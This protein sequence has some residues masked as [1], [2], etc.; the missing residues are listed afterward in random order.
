MGRLRQSVPKSVLGILLA[1]CAGCGQGATSESAQRQTS[2]PPP[3]QDFSLTLS[4]SSV[5]VLQGATTSALNISV[6]GQ[7]G[8]AGG[9]QVTL[10]GLPRGVLSNPASP[11]SMA[12]NTSVPVVLGAAASA[13][14][15]NFNV[16]VVGTSN[17]LSHSASL[18]LV[19]Q[20]GILSGLPRTTYV[21]TDSI[22]TLDDPR[23]NLATAG[24]FTM[25]RINTFLWP[26]APETAWKFSP[27]WIKRELPKSAFPGQAAPIFPPTGAPCGWAPS[28]RRSWQLI[29]L[30]CR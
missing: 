15:G 29:R 13:M 20:K 10:G 6:N 30:H 26:I 1:G 8:F 7:N 9:V 16:A 19:V 23:E 4:S 25:L 2:P 27:R 14:T 3:A 12:A 18:T 22:A 28:S 21:R 5:T 24:W 11:I 17:A